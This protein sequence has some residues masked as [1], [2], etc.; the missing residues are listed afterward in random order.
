MITISYN[1][2]PLEWRVEAKGIKEQDKNLWTKGY[3]NRQIEWNNLYRLVN[4]KFRVYSA[5]V[6][7]N[8]YRN[9]KN[10]LYQDIIIFDVDNDTN[11]KVRFLD[12]GDMLKDFKCLVTTTKS[13]QVE[14]NGVKEDR[15]RIIIKLKNRTKCDYKTYTDTMK[16][17]R[18]NL[19]PFAD[20]KC[21]DSAR[22]YFGNSSAEWYYT[23]GEEFDFDIYI[24]ILNNMKEEKK[25]IQKLQ[26]TQFN[27][28]ENNNIIEEFNKNTSI[29]EL[30]ELYGYKPRGKDR[31]ISPNS[32]SGLAGVVILINDD[33]KECAYNHHNSDDWEY[34]DSFG[35]YTHFEHNGDYK[36][37][38]RSLKGEKNV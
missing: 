37:A 12:V 5:G 15:Y 34:L 13:H 38:Y 24:K 21:V 14:K 23:D 31:F 20:A 35:L 10:W 17:I 3:I 4:S 8:G 36:Q 32:S 16:L 29:R 7:R 25:K 30:L 22:F 28:S 19:F 1:E 33:G 26:R 2:V 18:D 9:N 27:Y 6:F 11:C